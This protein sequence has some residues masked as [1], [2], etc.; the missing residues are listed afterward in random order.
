MH[1]TGTESALNATTHLNVLY[2]THRVPFPPNRGD[3]IRSFHTL[4]YLHARSRVYLGCL[5]DEP[6]DD[7]VMKVLRASC[8]EL[9][10]V[11]QSRATRWARAGW[12][13][14]CGRTAT[15]GLFASAGL[16]QAVAGWSRSIRFD[17]VLAYCSSMV[18]HADAVAQENVPLIVDLVDVDSQKWLDYSALAREPKRTLYALEGRRLRNLEGRI[19]RRAQSVTLVSEAEAELFRR[20]CPND[21]TFAVPNGVDLD[22]FKPSDCSPNEFAEAC[23]FVGALDYRANIDGLEWF[24]REVWPRVRSQHSDMPLV[25]VGRNPT[26]AVRRLAEADGVRLIGEVPDVRPYLAQAAC[27]VAPLRIARGIQ[28]KVLEAFAMAKAVVASPQALEGLTASPGV[29]VMQAASPSEWSDHVLRLRDNRSLR[30]ELGRN[31][32]RFVETR[33]SWDACLEPLGEILNLPPAA[34]LCEAKAD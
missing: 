20:V 12:S 1:P 29:E 5:T 11:R 23:V 25:I 33:H 15:E 34:V 31:A 28:N 21:H 10:V 30:A 2:L 6:I 8:H 16:R 13:G 17:A 9:A 4:Q 22:Y 24:C 14:L 32:R 3:R 27:V 19:A 26:T 18:Q 7:E